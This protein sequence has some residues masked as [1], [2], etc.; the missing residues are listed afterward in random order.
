MKNW[1]IK[2]RKR[3]PDKDDYQKKDLSGRCHVSVRQ[4][5]NQSISESNLEKIIKE[6]GNSRSWQK[7]R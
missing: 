1:R 2:Q 3:D 6:N 4:Y 5:H 7:S